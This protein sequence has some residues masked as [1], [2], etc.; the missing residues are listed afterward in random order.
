MR[1]ANPTLLLLLIP[2]PLILGY[3]LLRQ[4]GLIV[5]ICTGSVQGRL[6][7]IVGAIWRVEIVVGVLGGQLLVRARLVQTS[8]WL[9]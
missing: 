8:V 9:R 2:F 7:K 3:R 6:E 5:R 4:N 1:S